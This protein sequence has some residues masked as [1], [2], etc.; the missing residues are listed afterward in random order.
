MPA[1]ENR[2]PEA[3]PPSTPLV[4]V[5]MGVSGSG[6][7]TV[8]GLLAG[9]LGWDLAEGD[10]MHPAANVAKMAAGH[11]LDDEDRWPW[12]DTIA[13]WI[14]Q[15]E[16]SGTPGIITCSALKKIYRD[17]L[18]GHD[19][20]FVFLS[21]SQ[22]QIATRLTARHGHY[23][24]SSLL[25]SQIDTLEAPTADENALTIA[26]GGTPQHE[27]TEIVNRLDLKPIPPIN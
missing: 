25:Q 6:K 20:V 9:R 21:G 16:A 13:A 2:D 18:R 7:S 8:A 4:L 27:V 14:H 12:L 15:H 26:V 3:T 22:D 17:R 24:P 11:P 23:M 19:V 10:D 5:I 1:D